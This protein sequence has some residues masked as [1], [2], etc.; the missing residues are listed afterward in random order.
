M[1]PVYWIAGLIGVGIL[2]VEIMKYEKNPE[3]YSKKKKKFQRSPVN[4]VASNE[5]L[6]DAFGYK[7]E[8]KE[9]SKD[10]E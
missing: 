8:L 6:F 10:N 9:E 5:E 1:A 2:V 7:P 4:S 3:E